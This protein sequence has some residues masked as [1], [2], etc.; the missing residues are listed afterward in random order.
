MGLIH[1]VIS[2]DL[3]AESLQRIA[4]DNNSD[5]DGIS[6]SIKFAWFLYLIPNNTWEMSTTLS[7]WD[8]KTT[9]Y[10]W[11]YDYYS[12]VSYR[13]LQTKYFTFTKVLIFRET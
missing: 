9:E 2:T 6:C 7:I 4:T 10:N 5:H 12:L 8:N 13:C 1:I 3:K 11:N